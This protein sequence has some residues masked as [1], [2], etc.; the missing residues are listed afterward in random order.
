LSGFIVRL[1]IGSFQVGRIVEKG[2]HEELLSRESRYRAFYLKQF[3][4]KGADRGSA[5]GRG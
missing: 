1:I 4:E 5:G 2:R 3:E